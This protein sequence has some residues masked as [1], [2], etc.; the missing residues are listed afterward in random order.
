M[1]RNIKHHPFVVQPVLRD[2]RVKK[3]IQVTDSRF[4]DIMQLNLRCLLLLQI[5]LPVMLM[6]LAQ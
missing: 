2:R 3:V 6:A 5:L 1:V 4:L